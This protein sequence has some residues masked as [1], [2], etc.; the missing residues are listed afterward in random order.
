MAP[1]CR[2]LR[3]SLAHDLAEADGDGRCLISVPLLDALLI[4]DEDDYY[5]EGDD[6]EV[7]TELLDHMLVREQRVQEVQNKQ[8]ATLMLS[9]EKHG[10]AQE[11]DEPKL[12]QGTLCSGVSQLLE[13]E[14]SH[15]GEARLEP[16][17]ASPDEGDMLVCGLPKEVSNAQ[18]AWSEMESDDEAADAFAEDNDNNKV[19][20]VD[21]V[22]EALLI[23]MLPTLP[24]GD[25]APVASER[26]LGSLEVQTPSDCN[27]I[28]HS[29]SDGGVDVEVN[30]ST[31]STASPT[32]LSDKRTEADLLLPVSPGRAR[33]S[34]SARHLLWRREFRV[35]SHIH[36]VA[37]GPWIPPPSADAAVA[38]GTIGPLDH[39][40]REVSGTKRANPEE[41]RAPSAGS[42]SSCSR[43]FRPNIPR[44]A[45]PSARPGD[46]EAGGKLPARVATTEAKVLAP[47]GK[48]GGPP[49][50]DGAA[51]RFTPYPACGK[52][53]TV[54]LLPAYVMRKTER[55]GRPE[56]LPRLSP[57]AQRGAR[58]SSDQAV[59]RLPPV[60][61]RGARKKE[62]AAAAA[63]RRSAM[64]APSI[65]ASS[66][67]RTLR[68]STRPRGLQ[69]VEW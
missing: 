23:D 16:I 15:Q 69:G 34:D 19:T 39:R 48:Q 29:K 26:Y 59:L 2:S 14:T 51:A 35:G 50:T 37:K 32:S 17:I 43:S 41:A 21:D 6:E 65:D 38:D 56:Q 20:V 1:W 12:G 28:E 62:P 52:V 36:E 66:G 61:V 11:A 7:D 27:P 10:Q 25:A 40:P 58:P 44:L 68:S 57:D 8:Y 64:R 53:P 13:T 31:G 3:D 33:C 30:V 18:P 24:K 9:V 55:P 4:E 22:D 60:Q 54:S 63:A 5:Y 45:A 46:S 67:L 47:A 42:F 49:S